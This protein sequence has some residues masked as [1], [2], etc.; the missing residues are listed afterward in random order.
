MF[1]EQQYIGIWRNLLTQRKDNY[2][3]GE[4]EMEQLSEVYELVESK[5]LK[6]TK[7]HKTYIGLESVRIYNDKHFTDSTLIQ[8]FI[9]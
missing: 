4:R 8:L 9:C 3:G 6:N 5:Q 1:Q 7:K 2:L